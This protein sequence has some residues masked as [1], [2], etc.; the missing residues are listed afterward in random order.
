MSCTEYDFV[1]LNSWR[2]RRHYAG[3]CTFVMAAVVLFF[4]NLF[5]PFAMSPLD[6]KGGYVTVID[7]E[8]RRRRQF[9][10]PVT[11]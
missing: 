8:N 4:K 1:C 10:L 5:D 2:A 3:L 7:L 6:N 9:A 11:R